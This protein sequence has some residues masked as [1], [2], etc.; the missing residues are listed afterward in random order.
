[1]TLQKLLPAAAGK[2]GSNEFRIRELM[3]DPAVCALTPL[4]SAQI[5]SLF[6]RAARSGVSVAGYVVLNIGRDHGAS[7]WMIRGV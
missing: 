2:F 5:G 4:N 3:Q 6:S 7:L 1:M